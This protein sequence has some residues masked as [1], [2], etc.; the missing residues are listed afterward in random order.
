MTV[1]DLIKNKDYD[2]IEYRITL[3]NHI[4]EDDMFFGFCKSVNGELISVDGDSY[5]KNEEVLW[6]EEKKAFDPKFGKIISELVVCIEGE[7]IS[8]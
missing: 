2:I 6:Y 1:G 3:P 4:E 8:G 7:W 5:Y